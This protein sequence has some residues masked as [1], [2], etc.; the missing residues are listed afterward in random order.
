MPFARPWYSLFSKALFVSQF[1]LLDICLRGA[2]FVH[3]WRAWVSACTSV[4]V[5][6]VLGAEVQSRWARLS[7]SALAAIT[8]ITELQF[9]RY[10][11]T[12]IDA[13]SIV[14]ASSMWRDVAPV[15]GQMLPLIAVGALCVS[16]VE[17]QLLKVSPRLSVRVRQCSAALAF[18]LVLS[19]V[20]NPWGPPELRTLWALRLTVRTKQ[21]AAAQVAVGQ[22]TSLESRLPVLPNVLFL[23]SE[24]VRASD[25]SLSSLEAINPVW[26][27]LVASRIELH[28]MRSL[29]S[30][31]S[32]SVNAL[33]SGI[34]PLGTRDEIAATPLIFE[35]L[36]SVHVGGVRPATIYWSAQGSSAF[37]RVSPHAM[38]DSVAF[39][40]EILG[41]QF[42]T[43]AELVEIGA[44]AKLVQYVARRLPEQVRPV[45]LLVHLT[46]THAPYHVDKDVTPFQPYSHTVSWAG[47]S[48]LHNAYKNAIVAQDRA[49][50]IAVE[51]FLKAVGEQPFLI[52]FTSDHGEAFGEHNAIH[53]GQNL[54]DE[55]IH[56]PAWIAFGNGAL[57]GDQENA[58]RLHA[59]D[60]TT[61]LDWVPTL[62]DLYGVF[63]A[64]RVSGQ[65]DQL[66]GRSLLR[67][68]SDQ[69]RILPITNCTQ[70][71]P[72]PLQNYGLIRDAVTLLAQPWN[73][74]WQC[75]DANP[76]QQQLA[77]NSQACSELRA[78]SRRLYPKLPSG[79]VN[80]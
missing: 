15:L 55:Q 75:V 23:L 20:P 58:L 4:L 73:D 35:W 2:R 42:E 19:A 37:E 56:V 25:Y 36:H 54:Y 69:T 12:F 63:D 11:H 21:A 59:Q 78:A 45:F 65:R 38:A 13:D 34:M 26:R 30:Y 31:T 3:D 49:V 67:P 77:L 51:A 48:A 79:A 43:I 14:C 41:G 40:D 68:F 22:V 16:A 46:D 33:L 61:H 24:S 18:L 80:Q 17:Y 70:H 76:P 74:K 62:L 44:D 50:S 1:A 10:Y 28:G 8:L 64:V 47:L 57:T 6:N 27:G 39:Y 29:S 66:L 71:F 9:F 72:C 5:W 32:I 60:F 52:V 7:I 53:H